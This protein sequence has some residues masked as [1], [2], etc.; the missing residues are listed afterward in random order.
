MVSKSHAS[1]LLY[2]SLDVA[3]I[4][5]RKANEEYHNIVRMRIR[6]E[7]IRAAQFNLNAISDYECLA[8]YWF[9]RTDVGIISDMINF[10]E[11]TARNGYI[12]ERLT[13]TCIFLHLIGT[14]IRWKEL[15]RKHVIACLNHS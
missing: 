5:T 9:K 12:C 14:P 7:E 13:A 1:V 3:Q 15:K 6:S 11:V 2:L 8:R 10:D 4:A